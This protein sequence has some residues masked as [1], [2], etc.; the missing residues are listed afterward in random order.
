MHGEVTAIAEPVLPAVIHS[1]EP[2]SDDK[3]EKE[4][5]GLLACATRLDRVQAF[6]RY[7]TSQSH[8][9]RCHGNRLGFVV[10]HAFNNH[11]SGPVHESAA[12][13]L[14]S[15]P[16]PFLVRRWRKG[17]MYSPSPTSVGVLQ[18]HASVVEQVC[19]TSDGRRAASASRDGT[20]RIWELDSGEC[21]TTLLAR[22]G[23]LSRIVITPDGGR[24]LLGNEEGVSVWDV[25][26]GECMTMLRGLG[27]PCRDL[28]I[29]PD[30]RLV[31]AASESRRLEVW[32]VEKGVCIAALGEYPDYC[33]T[34]VAIA[35]DGR[36]LLAAANSTLRVWN[37]DRSTCVRTLEVSCRV[38]GVCITPD[39]RRAVCAGSDLALR[40]WD[41]DRGLCVRT[42]QAHS[43]GGR[44]LSM[45]MTVDGR[46]ALSASYRILRLWDLDSG[47][48][49]R[50]F[51]GHS[52]TV[53]SVGMAPDGAR[54]VSGG[55]DTTLRVWNLV[56]GVSDSHTVG[57]AHSVYGLCMTPDGCR[58][59]SAG[60]DEALRVWDVKSAEC[61]STLGGHHHRVL[62]VSV[63]PNGKC[64]VSGGEDC[65][66]RLWDLDN[67]TCVR[68]L[69]GHR[70]GVLCVTVTPDGRR[71]VSACTD[72][73]D[74]LECVPLSHSLD[75]TTRVWDLETGE[76]IRTFDRHFSGELCLGVTPD[77]C[78]VVSGGAGG[79]CLWDMVTGERLRELD[80]VSDEIR[81]L[82]VTLDGRMAVSASRK[83]QLQVWDLR[84]GKCL[85]SLDGQFD[86]F[87]L[88]GSA[89]L[90]LTD[91][92]RHAVSVGK[93]RTLRLWDI[94]TGGCGAVFCAPDTP[95]AVAASSAP[96]AIVC[97]TAA[98]EV[99]FMELQCLTRG[100]AILTAP[101]P[102]QRPAEEAYAPQVRCVRCGG[103]FEPQRTIINT[104]KCLSGDMKTGRAPCLDLPASAFS[105]SRLLS[106]CPHCH[107]AVKFNPF[108]SS[109]GDYAE[110]LRR[111]LEYSRHARGPAHEE[112]LAHLAALAVHLEATGR[113][114][115]AVEFEREHDALAAQ[116]GK[117][118]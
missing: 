38:D 84:T 110:E 93:D 41:L 75:R 85:E 106:C 72:I 86:W 17:A 23:V 66:L 74:H 36:W 79:L 91:D 21:V 32:D 35:A 100:P 61:L 71:A 18:G 67:G 88:P 9:L 25:R 59:V 28:S 70:A 39:G 68:T 30:G 107:S 22:V 65:T 50:T 40:V 26:R 46:L 7:V 64:A 103:A 83:G 47:E 99:V 3:I 97:G 1:I 95:V 48:C 14:D 105:D 34:R 116:V 109:A 80:R 2:W 92:G 76:C 55:W 54:A 90:S 53:R 24:L 94:E 45:S 19:I 11:P 63:T 117:R 77:G 104:I 108:F 81:S 98:G 56:N 43:E 87:C 15:L 112:T 118:K 10:Q 113:H 101:Y 111:G 4:A 51:Q 42:L 115:E 78:H 60:G 29:T 69:C 16:R 96:G 13:L 58:A 114:E 6:A 20:L 33:S 31:A 27:K 44:R 8:P 82:A 102:E 5:R 12:R 37:L 52:S 57:H 89:G 73:A 49:L 62:S